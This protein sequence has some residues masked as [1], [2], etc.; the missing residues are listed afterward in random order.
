MVSSGSNEAYRKMR[1]E[2]RKRIIK[3]RIQL[4]LEKTIE[5]YI[6]GLNLRQRL[7]I[8]MIPKGIV[9]DREKYLEE[10]KKIQKMKFPIMT[11]TGIEGEWQKLKKKISP[12]RS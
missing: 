4:N 10:I 6:N 2:L 12:K 7:A 5:M 11:I 3:E 8:E 1:A 9:E